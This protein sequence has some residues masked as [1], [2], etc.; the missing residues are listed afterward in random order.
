MQARLLEFIEDPIIDEILPGLT[1]Y[2]DLANN[3]EYIV[4]AI[5]KA[6]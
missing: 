4:P 5:Q 1:N 3:K 6:K 2:I